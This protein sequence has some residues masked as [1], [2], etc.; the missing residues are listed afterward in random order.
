MRPWPIARS[1]RG[2]IARSVVSGTLVLGLLAAGLAGCGGEPAAS[3]DSRQQLRL[4]GADGNMKNA[5]GEPVGKAQPGLIS[6]MK[7]TTPL[8]PLTDDFKAR[9]RGIDPALKDYP[10]AGESYDAIVIMALA[11]Q[12]ARTTRPEIVKQYVDGVTTGGKVCADVAACLTLARAGQDL[13]YQ[14]I[15]VKTGFKDSGEPSTT[16]YGTLHFSADSKINSQLTEFVG[17]GSADAATHSEGPAPVAVSV[18]VTGAPL[19]IGGLT[20]ITGTNSG[21]NPPKRAGA[22]LALA[23][24]NAAGGVLGKPIKFLDGDDGTDPV[25]AKA[26][27]AA[28]KGQGATMFFGPSGSGV[29]KE[30]I[31]VA[32]AEHVILFAPSATSAALSSINDDGYFFRAAPSDE[33][34]ARALA[35]VIMRDGLRK[36]SILYRKDTYGEGLAQGVKDELMKAGLQDAGVQ[37]EAYDVPKDAASLQIPD[38][39]HR[40]HEFAPEG[41]L[42]VGLTESAYAILDLAAGGVD[43]R[44]SPA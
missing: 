44:V 5:I 26:T 2:P 20:A 7:G 39:V 6:G 30:L 38:Q 24:L 35:D 15:T 23:E 22:K 11:T 16:S 18:P 28:E 43:P 36:L 31:P 3:D 10:Y 1:H 32:A 4:Y 17:A 27:L 42:V 21:S 40:I 13:Q 8:T 33:L 25:K 19:V 9:L 34:Q 12:L 14:G 29:A 41:V 37:L